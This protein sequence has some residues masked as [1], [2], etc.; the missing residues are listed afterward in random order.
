MAIIEFSILALFILVRWEFKS[1]RKLVVLLARN[2][3]MHKTKYI[4]NI[5]LN[6]KF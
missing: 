3:D 1:I 2:K 5:Y 6:V 4:Q